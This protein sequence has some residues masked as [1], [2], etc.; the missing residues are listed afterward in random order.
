MKKVKENPPLSY[1]SWNFY[2]ISV[3][4]VTKILILERRLYP[5]TYKIIVYLQIIPK[6]K[7][8]LQELIDEFIRVTGYKLIFLKNHLYFYTK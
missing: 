4:A 8:P 3:E 7:K 5:F 2:L 6:E 1:M